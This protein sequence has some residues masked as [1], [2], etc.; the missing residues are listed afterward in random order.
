MS[1]NNP[2][3]DFKSE[4]RFRRYGLDI[5]QTELAFRMRVLGS[6]IHPAN[7]SNWEKGL[8]FP[9]PQHMENL[10]K[11]LGPFTYISTVNAGKRGRKRLSEEQNVQVGFVLPESQHKALSLAAEMN[12]MSLSEYIRY[13]ISSVIKSA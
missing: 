13:C 9:N 6:K 7:V 3:V 11:V 4:L 2:I 10:Q 1:P 5:T 12:K 8:A